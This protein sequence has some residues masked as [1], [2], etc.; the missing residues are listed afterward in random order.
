MHSMER[1]LV[2]DI[3]ESLLQFGLLYGEELKEYVYASA[4]LEGLEV[5]I[6][7]YKV[8]EDE[9]HRKIEKAL[10]IQEAKEEDREA[11]KRGKRVKREIQQID[12]E[13]NEVIKVYNRMKDIEDETGLKRQG[14]RTVCIGK[15]N[16]C[17]G[18]VWKYGEIIK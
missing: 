12:P 1:K 16:T 17:G 9:I 15:K 7:D 11:K 18:Y 8:L 13:T 2:L 4:K 3:V 14:I 10:R 5:H 6:R